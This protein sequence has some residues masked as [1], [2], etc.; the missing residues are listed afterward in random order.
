MRPADERT[1]RVNNGTEN[2]YDPAPTL[3]DWL[4]EERGEANATFF[5][6]NK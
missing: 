6:K 4:A 3:Y 2:T 5:D 1:C